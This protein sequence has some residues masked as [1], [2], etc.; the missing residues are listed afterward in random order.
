[1][2]LDPDADADKE[3]PPASGSAARVFRFTPAKWDAFLAANSSFV[4]MSS[5]VPP[6][7][8]SCTKGA[9]HHHHRSDHG[10]KGTFETTSNSTLQR[11]ENQT[12]FK[13]RVGY[14]NESSNW[15]DP[16]HHGELTHALLLDELRHQLLCLL[17]RGDD[18]TPEPPGGGSLPPC[19]PKNPRTSMAGA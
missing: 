2:L 12:T 4:S 1:M 15:H 13:T 8:G 10:L 5:K 14:T 16:P 9:V 3:F 17:R 7:C 18:Q 6:R 19:P 11:F